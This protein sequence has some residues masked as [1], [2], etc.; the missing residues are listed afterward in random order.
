M[1]LLHFISKNY[2]QIVHC[3]VLPI[4]RHFDRKF[5]FLTMVLS[6]HEAMERLNKLFIDKESLKSYPQ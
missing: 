3:T 4:K 6:T 5:F 2:G 1:Y